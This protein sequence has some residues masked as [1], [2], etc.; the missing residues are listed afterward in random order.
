MIA[1]AIIGLVKHLYLT[2]PY[3]L[4]PWVDDLRRLINQL[5]QHSVMFARLWEVIPTWYLL[6][7]IWIALIWIGVGGF[8]LKSAQALHG[9]IRRTQREIRRE[10]WKSDARGR[11][12]SP[13]EQQ[14]RVIHQLLAPAEPWNKT[15]LGIVALGLVVTI[16]GGLLLHLVKALL[17]T[18]PP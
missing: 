8:I 5:L 7:T 9:E 16:V 1:L 6:Y 15:P 12:E 11:V 13:Q 14:M 4:I 18:S 10:G 17:F 2:L 3:S